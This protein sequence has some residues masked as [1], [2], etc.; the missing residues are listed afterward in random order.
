MFILRARAWLGSLLLNVAVFRF[1][2]QS[3]L[4]ATDHRQMELTSGSKWSPWQSWSPCSSTCGGGVATRV[5]T[6]LISHRHP[7]VKLCPG[8]QRQYKVC[9]VEDCP[10]GTMDFREL[11]CAAYNGHRISQIQGAVFEWVPFYG[12]PSPCELSCL[13]KGRRF[14]YNFGRVLDGT[15]CEAGSSGVCINGQCL[16]VGCGAILGSELKEDVCGV[17]GG[18]NTT[19]QRFQSVFITPHLSPGSLQYNEVTT[20]PAGATYIKVTDKSSNYLALQ[21]RDYNYIINGNL[22]I[23]WPGTYTAAG[24][25]VHYRRSA[26][27]QESL[28]AIGPTKEDLHLMVLSMEQDSGINYEYWLPNDQ[29]WLYHGDSNVL[30]GPHH[31]VAH[32]SHSFSLASPIKPTILA[33]TT[34]PISAQRAPARS[35]DDTASQRES[36]SQRNRLPYP[37]RP[38]NCGKCRRVRGKSNRIRQ[39]CERDFALHVRIINKRI[40]GLETRYDV[41][42]L[43]AYKKSFALLRRE[44]LWVPNTCD[45]PRMVEMKQYVVIARRHVNYE[46]TL[47]RVLLGADSFVRR[48]RPREDRLM[49]GLD[50]ECEKWGYQLTVNRLG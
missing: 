40:V 25:K 27:H 46:R 17:C 31:A 10:P 13:A 49:R 34:T 48:Y 20:I 21:N 44:Y 9:A 23:N 36:W 32:T 2:V 7:F 16:A 11:Q 12:A 30:R 1:I 50:G 4:V 26:D 43:K 8:N 15:K 14:Y 47:N 6:C 5:R 41:D 42:V 35:R 19:C 37:S 3:Q 24:T 22:A 33:M 28:E 18:R 39:Y 38:G 45:C 29:Y